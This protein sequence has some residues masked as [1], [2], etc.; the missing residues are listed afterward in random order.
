MVSHMFGCASKGVA[1]SQ[2]SQG[3]DQDQRNLLLDVHVQL[4]KD[5]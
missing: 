1:V 5:R 3:K 4:D 2:E